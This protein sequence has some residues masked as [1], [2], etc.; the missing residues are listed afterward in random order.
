M[1][2]IER[3][4]DQLEQESQTFET[5]AANAEPSGEVRLAPSTVKGLA[6]V[7]AD[8]RFAEGDCKKVGKTN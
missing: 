3:I 8:E 2:E 4:T 7:C 6:E 5:L 1:K